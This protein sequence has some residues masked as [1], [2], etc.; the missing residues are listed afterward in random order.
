MLMRFSGDYSAVRTS[1]IG[2]LLYN[3][4]INV[5]ELSMNKKEDLRHKF[6]CWISQRLAPDL[7]YK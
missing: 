4:K 2:A 1:V 6:H 5:R 7:P 3:L